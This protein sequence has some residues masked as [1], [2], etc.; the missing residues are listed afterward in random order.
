LPRRT[1]NRETRL[2][3]DDEQLRVFSAGG[4]Q[5][6]GGSQRRSP[7]FKPNPRVGGRTNV[8]GRTGPSNGYLPQWPTPLPQEGLVIGK[9]DRILCVPSFEEPPVE[10][11]A[12]GVWPGLGSRRL[13]Q[14]DPGSG[15][16][17]E[18]GSGHG[19]R[20]ECQHGDG[21]SFL[22]HSIWSLRPNQRGTV[23]LWDL[24]GQIIADVRF[25]A[26]FGYAR[27]GPFLDMN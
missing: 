15:G 17:S 8:E 19:E 14:A 9:C 13:G 26:S 3:K 20:G 22:A 2:G 6:V 4:R 25:F 7:G 16:H 12:R 1:R 5:G 24:R 18:R 11:A 21:V 27:R 10:L 23:S